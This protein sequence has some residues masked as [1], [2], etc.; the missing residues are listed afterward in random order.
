MALVEELA[1]QLQVVVLGLLVDHTVA[2]LCHEEHKGN[3]ESTFDQTILQA[4]GRFPRVLDL[5]RGRYL[6]SEERRN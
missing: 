2:L 6:E 5:Q 3:G 1:N 4:L